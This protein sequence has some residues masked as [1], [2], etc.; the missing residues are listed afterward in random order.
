[1]NL[2]HQSDNRGLVE[3]EYLLL[4]GSSVCSGAAGL[5]CTGRAGKELLVL[6]KCLSSCERI[7]KGVG[8][9]EEW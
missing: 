9:H 7:A 3:R 6:A 2:Q 1:M 5:T 4:R 8:V